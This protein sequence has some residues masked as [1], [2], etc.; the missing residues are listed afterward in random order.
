[1]TALRTESRTEWITPPII[2][3]PV[4]LEFGVF[5]TGRDAMTSHPQ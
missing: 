2:R 1:M 4:S 3:F 5:A